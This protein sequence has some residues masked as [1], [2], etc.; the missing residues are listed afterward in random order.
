MIDPKNCPDRK[1]GM[2]HWAS[3]LVLSGVSLI[4]VIGFVFI[5][6]ADIIKQLITK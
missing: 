2:K 6:Q 5:I 1:S 4:M 3:S